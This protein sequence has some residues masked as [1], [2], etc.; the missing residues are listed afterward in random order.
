MFQFKKTA[1]V[2]CVISVNTGKNESFSVNHFFC[3]LRQKRNKRQ[4][5]VGSYFLFL[6]P[7]WTRQHFCVKP[8]IA[9][10]LKSDVAR[11]KSCCWNSL[12]M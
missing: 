1:T 3:D 10:A 9:K 4:R 6:R 5:C 12:H 8:V 11:L 2:A 7:D